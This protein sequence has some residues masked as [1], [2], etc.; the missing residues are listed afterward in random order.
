MHQILIQRPNTN[1]ISQELSQL[2]AEIDD[3]ILLVDRAPFHLLDQDDG[4]TPRSQF[5][6]T[7]VNPGLLEYA[8]SNIIGLRFD[9]VTQ[10]SLSILI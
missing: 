9:S 7:T 1:D 10:V 6:V 8:D 2:K 5:I 4:F 3:I